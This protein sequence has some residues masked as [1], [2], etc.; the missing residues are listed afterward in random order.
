MLALRFTSSDR[1]RGVDTDDGFEKATFRY[2][3]PPYMFKTRPRITAAP[4][5]IGYRAGFQVTTAG[6]QAAEAVLV[7]LGSM[8]HSFDMNQRQIQLPVQASGPG[9]ATLGGPPDARVAP[10]GHYLLFILDANR[11]PSVAKIV[12]LR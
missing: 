1:V 9:Y 12:R 7:G 5:T 6:P 4:A 2:Y 11:V 3:Y 8:T 10:A